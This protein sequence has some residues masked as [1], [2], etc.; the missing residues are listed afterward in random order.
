MKDLMKEFIEDPQIASVETEKK[1]DS[2]LGTIAY[3]VT[4]VTSQQGNYVGYGESYE[5][6][7]GIAK[8]SYDSGYPS[9]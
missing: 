7:M 6:A 8:L 4:I 2:D 5:T 3:K 9:F 1:I